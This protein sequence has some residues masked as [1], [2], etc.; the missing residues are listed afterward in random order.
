MH[1]LVR[2][3]RLAPTPPIRARRALKGAAL[4]PLPLGA[5]PRLHE[6]LG[7]QTASNTIARARDYTHHLSVAGAL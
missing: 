1:A 2:V 3:P 5:A 6:R 4:H 7:P